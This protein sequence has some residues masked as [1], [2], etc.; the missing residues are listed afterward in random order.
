MFAIGTITV[1]SGTLVNIITLCSI[2]DVTGFAIA[3]K[4]SDDINAILGFIARIGIAF[5]DIRASIESLTVAGI[6]F[7]TLAIIRSNGI[8]T[9]GVTVTRFIYFTLVDIFARFAIA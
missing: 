2:F 9:I 3:E 8:G 4:G 6:S 5:V 7:L 1:V